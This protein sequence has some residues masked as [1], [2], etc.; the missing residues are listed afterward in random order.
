MPKIT[1]KQKIAL[2][3]A[4]IGL[5][6]LAGTSFFYTSLNRIQTANKNIETLALPVQR[7]S[8]QLQLTLLKMAKL[9]S[10]AFSQSKRSELEDSLS[11]YEALKRE[12]LLVEKILAQK[13]SDQPQ[14][15]TLLTKAQGHYQAYVQ[16]NAAM[17]N[18]K[19][20]IDAAKENF[21]N[22]QAKFLATKTLASNSMIDLEVID[23]GDQG[24]L[25]DDVIATGTRVDDML[26]TLGN[27]L[28]D[29]GRLTQADA[30]E[31]HQQ[32]VGFLLSNI[33]SNFDYLKQQA[34]GL[35]T[36][37]L[38]TQFDT[39]L[40][41]ILGLL[42][43]PGELYLA[44]G[45]VVEQQLQASD[46]YV[47]GNT[48]FT[49]S[50]GMLNQLDALASQRFDDL[51]A[52]ADDEIQGAQTLALL[53]TVIF[54]LMASFIYFF[55]SKAMLRPLAA[56]NQ[57]LALIANGD[58]SARLTKQNEDEFGT[59]IDSMNTLSDSLTH[60]LKN[61]SRDAHRLDASAIT[62]QQQG[63]QI[64]HSA[65]EQIA[66][67]SQ[68]TTLVA[69]IHHSSNTV[70][71]QT[72]EAAK[73]IQ[74]ASTLGIEVKAIADNN[75]HRIE[76][77]CNNLADSV[78]VITRLSQHSNNIGSIL[79]TIS[80]IAEQTNLL[81]LNAA[82]EAARAGEHGRGFAV[83]ADEVRSLA[84]RT[85]ASTAEIQTMITAL[86]QETQ[87]AVG[88]IGQGQ[89]QA[90]E[91][92]NQ[93][94]TLHG[95]IEQIEN[96]LKNISVMSQSINQAATEQVQFS[97]QIGETMADTSQAA[98]HNA[99]E[100]SAMAKGSAELNQLAHSLTTSVER[101]KF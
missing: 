80:A 19:L 24:A 44:Q 11:A 61:I 56:I 75:Q 7:Q 5:L 25:L 94:S 34:I 83:V 86:Q 6:L 100:S 99:Q 77:L 36:D 42:Q 98:E 13:V 3:F 26:Y 41:Q 27:S 62:S 88:A 47:Q 93:S 50:F 4:T 97:H 89:I 95:S 16:Q 65:S 87:K 57:A 43:A 90:N 67:M 82:I 79:V 33:S 39:S 101:F 78:A 91:C 20:A 84:S 74:Q 72:D 30:I 18:A 23:A 73:Q 45:Q 2:G 54:I 29:L 71:T 70:H 85:Q 48:L 28:T 15:Q 10:Q 46:A 96:A 55:T 1:I 76:Q 31:T 49:A 60:L 68:A 38:L 63:Q 32:D 9:N 58:L 22:L 35:P 37:E 69:H 12:Y 8:S 40:Q 52:I 81:A 17:F 59:L 21:K 92:V 51:Q 53:M 64:A 14:M 66:R